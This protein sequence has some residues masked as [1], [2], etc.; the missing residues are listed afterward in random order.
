MYHV[1]TIDIRQGDA[2][3]PYADYA[4]LS[5][6][7]MFNVSNFYTR[8]LMTGLKKA[9]KERTENE[10]DVIRAVTEAIPSINSA[11]K[12]KYNLKVAKIMKDKRLTDK[13]KKGKSR[14][15]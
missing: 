9:E 5:S 15:S 4:S 12:D 2:G 14:E 10:Q 6:N 1:E 7:N 11:L 3:F 13:E 8:N